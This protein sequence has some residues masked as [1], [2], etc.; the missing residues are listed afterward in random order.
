MHFQ[1][2]Y[3]YIIISGQA[4]E[5]LAIGLFSIFLGYF[6]IHA[7][8]LDFLPQQRDRSQTAEVDE[9]K[10]VSLLLAAM[11]L[12]SV[13][14][15]VTLSVLHS[16]TE[17]LTLYLENP[18]KVRS[19]IV[20]MQV[21]EI[22]EYNKSAYRF[23][24]Y[25]ISI[26]Y[27]ASVLAGFHFTTSKRR[28]WISILP[29][30]LT[31][32]ISAIF[33]KRF[34]IFTIT[35]LWFISA[36]YSVFFIETQRQ[37]TAKHRLVVISF[38]TALSLVLFSYWIISLRAYFLE[39]IVDFFIE[40]V[41][42][43]FAG[44][45]SAFEKYLIINVD[46]E[47]T[48][49]LS[50]FRSVIKWI[51]RLGLMDSTQVQTVHSSFVNIGEG[52]SQYINTYTFVKAPYEDFGRLGVAI[53]SLIWGGGTRL[54]IQKLK[55]RFSLLNLMFIAVLSFSLIMTFYEFYFE[56]ISAVVMWF[57]IMYLFN[58]YIFKNDIVVIRTDAG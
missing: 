20:G 57:I 12:I 30:V 21:G 40:N 41:Y 37:A 17:G 23:G 39:D 3:H 28:R 25:L 10:L 54:M 56:G 5:I 35:G 32:L 42:S 7:M 11:G 6:F 34:T 2:P 14:I 27:P 4:R 44:T 24:S 15:L 33:I 52:H 58:M 36:I 29:L 9:E 26:I 31:L 48:W 13:G 8:Y 16:V 49:G 47:R 19:I 53:V 55:Q 50:S 43:Y 51:A 22:T 18:L 45:L 38:L 1:N 46:A